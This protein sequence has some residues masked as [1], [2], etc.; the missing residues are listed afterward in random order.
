VAAINGELLETAQVQAVPD[1]LTLAGPNNAPTGS[2][3]GTSDPTIFVFLPRK[4][5]E[6]LKKALASMI[7][8]KV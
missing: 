7:A 1:A 3:A 6:D 4:S 2:I 8:K 5:A